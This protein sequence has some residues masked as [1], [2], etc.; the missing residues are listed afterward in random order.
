MFK[1]NI[2]IKIV[3]LRKTDADVLRKWFLFVNI[4]SNWLNWDFFHEK[5][6]DARDGRAT[7]ATQINCY[8][9]HDMKR[10]GKAVG[11]EFDR[12]YAPSFRTNVINRARLVVSSA[13][14]LSLART[15]KVS[16]FVNISN[17]SNFDTELQGVFKKILE[18]LLAIDIN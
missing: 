12:L 14:S 6:R 10:I 17:V 11:E 15:R 4:M 18:T 3:N 7:V 1:I 13:M 9:S 5:L 2:K 16:I 8:L